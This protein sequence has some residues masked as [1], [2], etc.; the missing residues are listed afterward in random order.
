MPL[1]PRSVAVLIAF[2]ITLFLWFKY[3]RSSS[4]SSWHYLVTSS[5]ASPEILN[6]TL[7][8]QSIFTINLPSRTDRRDAVTLA[9]ALSG[10]D[11]TWIDGVASADVPDKVLPGG[12]TTMK[13]GNRGSWR[14]HMNA[15]QRIVE[16]N[17]TSAL[18]L[19]DDADWDIRLK[20]QM[21]V[22][23]HAAK[24][25]T[26]PLRSGSGRPLSSKYHDHPAPSIS[27]TKLP[28]PPSPKLTPYGDTWDLLWLGHCGTSFAASAQD[29][30]SIPISPLRV[31]IPSDPTVPP[32]RHLKPHPFALTDPLAE[33]YPPHTRVVHLSNGT[34]CTQA[35]A[36]SQQGA[37]KLLYRFGLAE[38]LTKGW[39]L[40]LGD[41]C[42]RGYHSSVAGDGDSNGGGGAGLPVCVTVQPPLFSH[43]YGAGG[44]G[45]SDI[46]APG[47]G[48]LRVG[49]GRLEKGMTPYVRW[50]VRLNMGKLVEGGS[51][52]VEGL[53]VD[54]W[55]EGKE[56]GL[57]RGGS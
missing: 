42:D 15:L 25:F 17:M 12:S 52:D 35:Y 18:I 45:K 1:R 32:P 2:I 26:Q 29:G 8:F 43:H 38:R 21:Q 48:F 9:A 46:S 39:D 34:T 7:G 19:E 14:A 53:V 16:Q 36:V 30:N 37:R 5:K 51:S 56:G 57:G 22:F 10:L 55:G 33:L 40:V 4:V 11:I 13:G 23:A 41:W 24:A 49:E 27:I 6:A 47:G 50:S 31:A 3:S 44:G 54:Q 28:S 20:S